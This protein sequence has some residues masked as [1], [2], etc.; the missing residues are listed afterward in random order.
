MNVNN[1]TLLGIPDDIAI[2]E[3]VLILIIDK[4]L[5]GYRLRNKKSLKWIK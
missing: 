2:N 1:L 3:F 4:R 5:V